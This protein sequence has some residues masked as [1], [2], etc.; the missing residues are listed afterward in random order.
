MFLEAKRVRFPA[1]VSNRI[2]LTHNKKLRDLYEYMAP[3]TVT[4]L[5]SRRPQWNGHVA[6]TEETNIGYR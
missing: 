2:R 4:A 5:K 6:R 3:V 1:A